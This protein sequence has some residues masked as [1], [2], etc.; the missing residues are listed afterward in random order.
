MPDAET[1][2]TEGLLK[3][4][5]DALRGRKPDDDQD[6]DQDNG[7][8][9]PVPYSRFQDQVRRRKDAESKLAVLAE[10]VAD[11]EKASQKE[12]KK[13]REDLAA[14]VAA[15]GQRHQDDL[16]LVDAGLTDGLGRDVLRQHV[17]S[18]PE[19]SR[20]KSAPE[21]WRGILTEHAAHLADPEK[22]K[23][24]TVPRALTPYL[25]APAREPE[26]PAGQ[27]PRQEPPRIQVGIVAGGGQTQAEA[28]GKAGSFSDLIK[29]LGG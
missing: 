1:P 15:L 12:L 28:I 22:V 14:Q 24:P 27:R 10:R 17:A 20:P 7:R 3:Q 26:P 4:I 25:P 19:A 23:A 16:A 9:R 8:D 29:A 13:A 2:T 11:L 18:L 5:A 6:D 21:Y